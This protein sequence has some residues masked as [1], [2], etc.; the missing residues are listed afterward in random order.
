MDKNWSNFCTLSIVHFMAFPETIGGEGPIVE[1]VSKI[2]EDPFFSGIEIGWIKDPKTRAVT[3]AVLDHSHIKVGYGAQPSLLLQGLNLNSLDDAE[4]KKAVDQLKANVDEAAEIGA[5]RVG[6]LS[7]KDPGGADRPAAL[8]A[9]VKSVKEVCA[10]AQDRGI[11]LTCETFDREI[12]KKCLIGPSDYAA[13][14]ARVVR[15][16]YPDFGLMYDLSHQ[17]LLFEEAEPALTL[18]K[19]VLVH[20]HIGNCVVD[21]DTP[22]Y[23]DLHPRFGWPGGCNDVD[24]LVEFLRALFKIGYLAEGEEE[25]PWVGFEVKPQTAEETSEQIIAGT[26]RVWQEAWSRV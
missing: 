13:E 5:R 16:D 12:D 19:D 2:A 25:R 9:L 18:L 3:R 1:T 17:P 6:F 15:E 24:E 22:G 10:Y 7:G 23:G 11:A 8:E 14:F 4:R 20:T 26:K 21:P